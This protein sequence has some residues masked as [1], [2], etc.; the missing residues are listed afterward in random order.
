MYYY[1]FDEVAGNFQQSNFGRGGSEFDRVNVD[2][3]DG[4]GLNNANFSTPPDGFQ[5]RMQMFEWMTIPSTFDSGLDNGIVIHEYAHGISTRLTGGPSAA[6]CLSGNEQMGEGWSDWYA[7]MFT[8]DASDFPEEPKVVGAYVLGED[9]NGAG[10][11]NFPYSTDLS[12]NPVTYD[13]IKSLSV[14]HGV[15]TVWASAL[16]D[17]TWNLIDEH[18]LDADIY[19]GV[20]GN[21][22]ALNLVTLALKL[23]PC[24]PGFVDGRDAILAAD[25]ILYDGMNTCLIWDAFARRGI[26]YFAEQGSSV[27]NTDGT[28]N[29]DLP[30]LCDLPLI[31]SSTTEGVAITSD[32]LAISFDIRTNLTA[33]DTGTI[34]A[35]LTNELTYYAGAFTTLKND[36]ITFLETDI[37]SSTFVNNE[38]EVLLTSKDS[39]AIYYLERVDR[40]PSGWM[41]TSDQGSQAWEISDTFP[42][43]DSLHFFCKNVEDN[44]THF[45]ISPTFSIDG[46]TFMGF[47]HYYNLEENWDGGF[48]ELSMDNGQTWIDIGL[49]AVSN[50]YKEK[51]KL[52]SNSFSEGRLAFSGTNTEYQQTIIDLSQYAGS[53][54]QI[55]FVLASDRFAFEEGWYIDNISLYHKYEIEVHSLLKTDEEVLIYD[56]LSIIV[57]P[58]CEP[59]LKDLCDS[60]MSSIT[61]IDKGLYTAFH[62]IQ[63]DAIIPMSNNVTFLAGDSILLKENFTVADQAIFQAIIDECVEP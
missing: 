50:G 12:V 63:S 54:I 48:V 42:Y 45:L 35:D 55:R 52:S 8:L 25:E 2:I 3:L 30:P 57:M 41:M 23:Q 14:P 22:M 61:S 27:S 6:S 5:A 1:G 16:W 26:G 39:S 10:I 53:D 13:D 37:D 20:G 29:F 32:T 38:I 19:N 40:V 58:A 21:N 28:E 62:S 11:R 33:L 43:Q 24:D 15:G 18:G 31:Y 36:S 4:S 7:L 46:P 60:V 9:A 44:Q 56:T 59:C 17:M 34:C 47:W 51:L 49:N